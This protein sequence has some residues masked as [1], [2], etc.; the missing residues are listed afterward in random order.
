MSEALQSRLHPIATQQSGVTLQRVGQD[1]GAWQGNTVQVTLSA[2]AAYGSAGWG[3]VISAPSRPGEY[4]LARGVTDA[5]HIGRRGRFAA[6]ITP[7][8]TLLE[9][10]GVSRAQIH[11][12]LRAPGGRRYV[13]SFS[14]SLSYRTAE[15]SQSARA[16]SLALQAASDSAARPI[17]EPEKAN[18]VAARRVFQA[19]GHGESRWRLIQGGQPP[20]RDTLLESAGDLRPDVARWMLTQLGLPS[21][22]EDG[23]VLGPCD[24]L[25]RRCYSTLMDA[26]QSVELGHAGGVRLLRRP[27]TLLCE[28]DPERG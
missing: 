10:L 15:P 19:R 5:D 14:L 13:S 3:A 7:A 11:H 26:L 2:R 21:L 4:L 6:V 9:E 28:V 27:G 20:E 12:D 17:S 1:A 25:G 22:P 23:D 8:C 18:W 16:A 24:R